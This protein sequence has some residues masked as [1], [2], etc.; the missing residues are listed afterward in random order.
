MQQHL[1]QRAFITRSPIIVSSTSI[2]KCDVG[3]RHLSSRTQAPNFHD[4]QIDL[5]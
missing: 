1:W 2:S 5:C 4:F 3:T